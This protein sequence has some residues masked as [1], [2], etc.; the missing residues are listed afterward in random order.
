MVNVND[1]RD[2]AEE[3]LASNDWLYIE[4]GAT[5]QSTQW[6]NIAAYRRYRLIP[7]QLVNVSAFKPEV[8]VFGKMY[9]IPVGISP[10]AVQMIAHW[11]GEVASARAAQERNT[12]FILSAYASKTIEEVA[13]GAPEVTKWM[14]IAPWGSLEERMKFINR[15]EAA[16]Y[17][18][19]VVTV[20]KS[21]DSISYNGMRGLTGVTGGN[22][23]NANFNNTDWGQMPHQWDTWE[24]IEWIMQ[25]TSLRVI[26][27][28]IQTPDDARKATEVGVDGIYVS[29]HG[30]R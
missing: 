1:Y 19:L 20:D 17:E 21:S 28:G 3:N 14:Q 16:G 24:D 5:E 25:R 8:E 9:D 7:T 11:D 2:Y 18:A 27:K 12:I 23:T 6:D 22:I 4:D 10:T 30:G 26:V 13:V 29:N 15:A